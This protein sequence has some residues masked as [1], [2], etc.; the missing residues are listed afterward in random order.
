MTDKLPE[1]KLEDLPEEEAIDRLQQMY[2]WSRDSAAFY[3]GI[4]TGKIDGDIRVVP[5]DPEATTKEEQQ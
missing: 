2:G 3:Y 1:L 4:A 5:A